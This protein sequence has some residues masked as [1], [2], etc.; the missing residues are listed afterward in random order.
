M[1][2][3]YTETVTQTPANF[4]CDKCKTAY[5]DMNSSVHIKHT[6]G[7]F[8]PEGWDGEKIDV[9]VCE[10]CLIALCL[11]HQLIETSKKNTSTKKD[12][13]EKR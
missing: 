12:S 11:Q 2:I 4:V 5:P 7:Y 1:P 8:S 13:I 3:H 10:G 9:I 6:F